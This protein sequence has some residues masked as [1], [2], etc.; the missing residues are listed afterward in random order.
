MTSGAIQCGVPTNVL[1]LVIVPVSWAATP[2]SASFTLP[3][4]P[5]SILAHLMSRCTYTPVLE[6]LMA[7]AAPSV[8][9]HMLQ[10]CFSKT[11]KKVT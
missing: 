2:K 11:V 3:S 9:P 8:T 6:P 4:A 5:S 1:R 7:L 10:R